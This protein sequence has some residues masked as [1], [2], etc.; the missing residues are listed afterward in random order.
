MLGFA[1]ASKK[2][3]EHVR[4]G[5]LW[6]HVFLVCVCATLALWHQLWFGR[7]YCRMSW[8]SLTTPTQNLNLTWKSPVFGGFKDCYKS[9]HGA[10]FCSR[11]VQSI[12]IYTLECRKPTEFLEDISCESPCQQPR[13]HQPKN[14]IY[15]DYCISWRKIEIP[16]PECGIAWHRFLPNAAKASLRQN[17]HNG[18]WP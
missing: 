4:F 17:L 8:C 10:G 6:Q 16:G 11:T 9:R 14:W 2:M 12:S 1:L 7:V 18:P 13:F 3:K 5:Q 15:H